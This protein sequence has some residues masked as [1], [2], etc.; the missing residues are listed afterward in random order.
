MYLWHR[1]QERP[2]MAFPG[3]SRTVN[4]VTWHPTIPLLFAS[5]SDDAT[6]RIWSTPEHQ[7]K[8]GKSDRLENID[9]FFSFI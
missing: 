8:L 4:C 5:A 3:H 7:M 1:R 2:I 6:I 9:R